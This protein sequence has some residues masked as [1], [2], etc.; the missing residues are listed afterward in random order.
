M[1]VRKAGERPGKEEVDEH[2]TSHIPF[3][4][5]CTHC[6]KGKADNQG[7]KRMKGK[8]D[9]SE[10]PVISVDYDYVNED[11]ETELKEK[12]RKRKE[13]VLEEMKAKGCQ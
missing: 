7:H 1:V 6:V 12:K 5:W 10:V 13:K 3:R 2:N 11:R 9:E 4:S 8:E